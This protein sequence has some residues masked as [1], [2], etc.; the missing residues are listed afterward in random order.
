MATW[1]K[2]KNAKRICARCGL[3]CKYLEMKKELTGNYVCLEC[4]DGKYQLL[5]HPL[6]KP[7]PF[8]PDAPLKDARPDIRP[9][10][11]VSLPYGNWDPLPW[12]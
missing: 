6:N 12:R 9:E 10:V 3:T 2:G 1:A 5:N 8:R 11:P 4:Y 7:A